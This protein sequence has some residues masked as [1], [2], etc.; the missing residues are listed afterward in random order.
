MY[1]RKKIVKALAGFIFLG[2]TYYYFDNR[3][4]EDSISRENIIETMAIINL[5]ESVVPIDK[6]IYNASSKDLEGTD[7]ASVEENEIEDDKENESNVNIDNIKKEHKPVSKPSRGGTST[8]PK[9]NVEKPKETTEN[10]KKD[11]NSYV[12]D[13]VK[14]YSLEDGKYPYLLNNDFK[15]YNGVTE[16]L[17]YGGQVL[18]KGHNS[19]N[20]ASNCTGITFEV[21]FKAMQ[22]RNND[23]GLSIDNFNGLSKDE[24]LDFVLTWYVALGP[25]SESNL[26]VAIEKYGFGNR[27]TDLEKVKPGDFI[28]FSRE[29]NTGHAV[30]F[31]NWIRENNKII[32]L[33]YWSSQGS[34][35]GISYKEEYFNIKDG[36]GKKY[37]NVIKDQLH[38]A[39]VNVGNK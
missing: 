36:N 32:G 24:L 29:N 33:K 15:N 3:N 28:D 6:N 9:E 2:V 4:V 8:A 35:N 5:S 31:I 10:E 22:K 17:Y 39:R 13:V 21:F 12:L 19:G 11:F 26:A 25:K 20:R 34:T 38:I 18:L 14:T 27:V 23:L 16:D 30:I 7:I 1:I 37:G